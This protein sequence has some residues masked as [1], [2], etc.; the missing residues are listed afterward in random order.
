MRAS[1][2]ITGAPQTRREVA[3]REEAPSTA[4][5]AAL[6][7]GAVS[8]SD[9]VWSLEMA[10]ERDLHTKEFKAIETHFVID[11]RRWKVN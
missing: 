10:I 11:G 3:K 7:D 8:V 1:D 9:D 2:G 6:A 5:E 4:G